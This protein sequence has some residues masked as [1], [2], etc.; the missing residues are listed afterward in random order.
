MKKSVI[1]M[2]ALTALLG[3]SKMEQELGVD[4]NGNPVGEVP[5]KLTGEIEAVSTRAPITS[6]SGIGGTGL[7]L[8]IFRANEVSGAFGT[9]YT[10]SVE[11]N[12]AS[13]GAITFGEAQAYLNNGDYSKFIAV[14]PRYA[15]GKYV[16]ADATV[17]YT[18]DGTTDILASNVLSGKKTAPITAAFSFSHL[19]TQVKV[20]VLASTEGLSQDWGKVKSITIADKQIAA[21]VKLPKPDASGSAVA[22]AKPAA[23]GT[24]LTVATTHADGADGLTIPH[25]GSGADYGYAMFL[26]GTTAETLTLNVVTENSETGGVTVTTAQQR[27]YTASTV[28]TITLTFTGSGAGGGITVDVDAGSEAGLNN[29]ASDDTAITGAI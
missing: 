7:D 1:M 28:F 13:T 17:E 10:R 26:K 12:L 2:L 4:A 29:W 15:D 24:A 8:H 6:L 9:T 19:L 25:T 14:Y 11:G 20:K 23:T 22:E 21:L 16:A 18:I 27:I 3:C 5:V